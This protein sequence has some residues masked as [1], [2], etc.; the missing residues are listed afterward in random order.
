[1]TLARIRVAPY[2]A[3]RMPLPTE[4]LEEMQA[5]RDAESAEADRERLRDFVRSGLVC[6][7]WS[8]LG[9]ALILWSAHTT[10]YVYG[11]IAFFAGLG[12]GNAGIL[13]TLMGLY[14]RGEKRG[15]W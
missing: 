4:M 14:R 5:R 11:W 12:I 9:V 2:P 8:L 1:V 3:P 6:L 15:D 13:F 7:L 10:S